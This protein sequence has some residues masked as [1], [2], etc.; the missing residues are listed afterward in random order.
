[1]APE[2]RTTMET[3]SAKKHQGSCHCGAVRFEVEVDATGGT[4]CNCTVCTKV[5]SVTT[6]VK[7]AAFTLLAGDGALGFYEWGFKTARRF[8]CKTCAVSCFVRGHL[9]EVGGDY[10]SV[11]LNC[12]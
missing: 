7:P 2:R 3:T 12:L 10:V 4:R 1:M 5:G 11:N 8:F 9:P 6:I